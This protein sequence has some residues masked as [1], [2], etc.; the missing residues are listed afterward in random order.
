[1]LA[2]IWCKAYIWLE[3]IMHELDIIIVQFVNSFAG[4]STWFDRTMLEIF[5]MATFKMMPLVA[6]LVGLWF[7]D[8]S[9]AS[10]S[11]RA[12]LNGI[13]GGFVALVI[14][15][16]IQNMAPH[17]PR[18]ALEGSFH[19]TL[20][21][22]GYTNDWSSFPSDSAGLAF[23]IAF[24]IWLASRRAGVFAFF[25]VI[26]VVSFP[27]LYGGYHYLSD[28]MAGW[29]IGFACTYF[30]HRCTRVS[31]PIYARV[32]R[33]SINHKAIFFALAFIVA[34]QTSTYFNDLRKTGER[35]L[36]VMGIK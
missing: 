22:G 21:A 31:E 20:P 28:L 36:H 1:M 16:L 25:W 30:F 6:L 7:V 9:P 4:K 34:F 32:T 15:R 35:V 29:I 14:T 24:G 10:K 18:P 26:C 12:V 27:R 11:R 33:F 8:E 23:A 19:F 2:K 3:G 5:R 13:L 17:R